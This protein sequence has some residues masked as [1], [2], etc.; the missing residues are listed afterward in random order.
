VEQHRLITAEKELLE[1]TLNK[2]LQVMIDLLSL[3]N[4]TAFYRT[5]R[6]KR[7]VRDIAT[8]LGVPN[9]WEV[10]IA[11]ML[12]QIG[13]ITIPEKILAK[14]AQNEPLYDS[15]KELYQN[16][17]QVAY[18]L[19]ARIPRL[20]TAA[21]IIAHQNDLF[22]A[23]SASL[24]DTSDPDLVRC[25]A[26]I[27]KVANDFDRL[28]YTG[29]SAL[30]AWQEL[31]QREG[32]YLPAILDALKGLLGDDSPEEVETKLTVSQLKPGMIL[33]KPLRS[34]RGDLI[35][36]AGTEITLPLILRFQNFVQAGMI[37]REIYVK[38]PM[39]LL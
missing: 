20:Q 32:W 8:Q 23:K 11:A 17:P 12:S 35:L 33:D 39:N 7:L 15:E 21:E 9:L 31:T 34:K 5:V 19:I 3:V 2:S 27:I 30:A 10:E 38:T 14:I 24:A 36:A 25:C 37:E 26:Q 4:S 13:C 29:K 22:S 18:K 16:H 28:M 6:V 1:Q